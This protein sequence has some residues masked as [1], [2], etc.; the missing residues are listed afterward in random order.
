LVFAV[1]GIQDTARLTIGALRDLPHNR[2]DAELCEAS[3]IGQAKIQDWPIEFG[4]RAKDPAQDFQMNIV[5]SGLH[6]Q[7]TKGHANFSAL[8]SQ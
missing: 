5:G 2:F 7:A 1:N 6:K 3:K 8:V 4:I